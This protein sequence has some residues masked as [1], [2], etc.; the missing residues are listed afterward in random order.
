MRRREFLYT[1]GLSL[2]AKPALFRPPAQAHSDDADRSP[3]SGRQ[4]VR[5]PAPTFTLMDQDGQA[6]AF[7]A[8]RGRAVVVTFG[9]TSCP[10]VCPL[11]TAQLARVQQELPEAGQAHTGWLFITTDPERDT[12][13]VLREYGA[14]LSADFSIW[15]F[16]TGQAAQV[17]PIWKGFGVS[18]K[19]FGTGQVDHTVLTT[20]VDSQGLR[21]VNYYGTRWEPRTLWR[22]VIMLAEGDVRQL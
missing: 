3:R 18:V 7:E 6:F 5:V 11:L 21:R 1:M 8:W 17:R 10:D 15:R 20:L 16:L 12:P 4:S 2:L 14:R 9:Y 19:K 22:D 13:A